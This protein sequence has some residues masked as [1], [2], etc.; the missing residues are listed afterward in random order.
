ML[1]LTRT[2][3]PCSFLDEPPRSPGPTP[4]ETCGIEV[5]VSVSTIMLRTEPSPGFARALFRDVKDRFGRTSP[6]GRDSTAL[7]RPSSLD[8]ALL[9]P[10][11]SLPLSAVCFAASSILASSFWLFVVLSV[12]GV[13]GRLA[14]STVSNVA[15]PLGALAEP[16]RRPASPSPS[17]VLILVG[18]KAS[19]SDDGEDRLVDIFAGVESGSDR[20]EAFGGP[21]LRVVPLVIELLRREVDEGTLLESGERAGGGGIFVFSGPG[22][23][24]GGS[25]ETGC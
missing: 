23:S 18:D 7:G 16:R 2:V 25:T 20:L 5:T 15:P 10:P 13:E 12:I 11:L 9:F 17:S 22:T 21:G 4:S 6:G 24:R 19:L 14:S 3:P 8:P 1:C